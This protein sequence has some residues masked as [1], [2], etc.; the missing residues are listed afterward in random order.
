MSEYLARKEMS[1]TTET[2]RI[3]R[4][5]IYCDLMS[6][7]IALCLGMR[8]I[9]GNRLFS[10]AAIALSVACIFNIEAIIPIE[11]LLFLAPAPFDSGLAIGIDKIVFLIITIG[12]LLFV[13]FLYRKI[14]NIRYLGIVF[15]VIT[16]VI[17]SGIC[18]RFDRPWGTVPIL[19]V[20]IITFIFYSQMRIT[21]KQVYELLDR[22]SVV[23]IIM[24]VFFIIQILLD[25]INVDNR[26][27][28]SE[29][30]NVNGFAMTISQISIFL[31]TYGLLS[32]NFYVKRICF[33]TYIAGCIVLLFTG[34]RSSTIAIVC[35][36]AFVY[37]LASKRKGKA[38]KIRHVLLFTV[39]VLVLAVIFNAI[40][41]SNEFLKQRF[42]ISNLISSGGSGR[43][44]SL[45][46]EFT[47]IIPDNLWL[48]VGPSAFAEVDAVYQYGRLHFSSHN[49]IGSMLT[50]LGLL[51]SI[52]L[53]ILCVNI[54]KR[55][56]VGL[57]SDV[58]YLIPLALVLTCL[59]NGIG[60]QIFNSR[61]YWFALS[62]S[63]LILNSIGGDIE[64]IR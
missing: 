59:I 2:K 33:T 34:T 25:P 29:E 62:F 11:F 63:V 38:Q 49:I 60:E 53:I 8:M 19:V 13:L 42:T 24:M 54:V 46:I 61:M 16:A 15:W 45:M 52:P 3:S 35:S 27:T 22:F 57:R 31:F 30:L 41:S 14:I 37:F 56:G 10:F 9:T 12:Q 6:F 21:R 48:G 20:N 17:A 28:V 51:G 64:T 32:K 50:Q 5:K 40:L 43:L 26:L 1:S 47:E 39:I 7:T 55:L 44:P 4:Y 58:K 18:S 36:S 23:C